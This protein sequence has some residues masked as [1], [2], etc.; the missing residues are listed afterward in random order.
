MAIDPTVLRSF[1]PGQLISWLAGRVTPLGQPA[2]EEQEMVAWFADLSNFSHLTHQITERERA[3]PELVGRLLDET[4]GTILETVTRYG[5]EVL[6]FAG[7]SVLSTWTIGADLDRARA[8][9]LASRCGLEVLGLKLPEVYSELPPLDLRVGIGVGTGVL[10]ELGG[11]EQQWHFAIG[12]APFDQ[13]GTASSVARPGEVVLSPEAAATIGSAARGRFDGEGFLRLT[14]VADTEPPGV[15]TRPEMTP[16]LVGQLRRFLAPPVLK[17]IE[18]G[19]SEWLAEF[20]QVT[21]LFVNLPRLDSSA[22]AAR[23][24]LQDV[25]TKTQETLVKYEGTLNRILDDDKGVT[26]FASFGLPPFAHEEDPYLAVQAAEEVQ[27][28][29]TQMRLEYGIGIATGRA[30]CGAYG[31]P[32]RREYTTIG[33]EVNLAARLMRAA[34]F[35]ILCDEATVRSAR[36]IEFHALDPRQLRGWD[37]PVPVFK[38]LWEK[39]GAR[40]DRHGPSLLVGRESEQ[41]QLTAWLGAL[42]RA[43]SSAVVVVEGE[44]G[45]GKTALAGDLIR[46]AG[47]F[48][49][50][51]LLGSALPVAQAPYQAWRDVIVELLGLTDIRS[52][53]RRQEMV[54][55]SLSRWPEFAQWEALLNS[56]L[57][58]Q[59]PETASTRGMSGRNRR[60]STVELLVALLSEAA[61]RS[62]L[63]IVLDDLQWFD[64]ASW[65]VT[66]AAARKVSPMLLVLLTR[67]IPQRPEQL[68]ELTD[69]GTSARMVLKPISEQDSLTLAEERFDAQEMGADVAKVIVE[70]AE[71]IPF[72]IEELALSLRESGAVSIDRGKVRLTRPA[73]ELGIPHTLSS[74]V[75]G[76]IDHLAPQLQLTVKVASVIG[77]SFDTRALE[78]VHPNHPGV[79]EL[80]GQ[81]SELIDLDLIVET[82]PE[83]YDFK[84]ALTRDTAYNLLLFD[85]RR[86]IHRSVATFFE[87]LPE[88]PHEPQYALLAYHWDRGD[89]PDKA[90]GY[91]EK[92]GASALRKGANREAIAAHTRSLELVGQYPEEFLDV[93]RL[94]QS[95]WHLEIGQAHEASGDFDEAEKNLYR[96]MGLVEVHVSEKPLRRLGRFIREMFKQISHVA[97][98]GMI[99][100]P[101]DDEEK[102]RLAQAA[103]TAALIGETY[104]FTGDIPGFLVLN[105]VAINLGEKSGEPLVAGLAY[106]S[107]GYLVGTLRLRR[108]ANRYFRQARAAE[109]LETRTE[110]P[111]TPHAPPLQEMGPGHLIAVALSESVLALT[112]NE[113]SQA[114]AIVTEALD[115]CDRLGDK[116]SAGIALAVRGFVSYSS[117]DLEEAMYDYDQLLA[118]AR[119]RSNREHEG[120]ATSFVIPVLLA[121][122]HLEEA[123]AMAASAMSILDDVDPLTVP[124]IHGTRSQVQLRAGHTGEARASAELALEA[125]DRTPFF[126]YLAG[127]AGLLDTLLE[128][129]AAEGDRASTNA[130]DLAKLTQEGLRKMR[131]FARVL[132]FARPK[133]WLFK[134]RSEL[135]KGRTR[136]GHRSLRKGL[137]LARSNGFTWDEGLLHLELAETLPAHDAS[138]GTHQIEARRLF[139]KVG[140]RHDL[141]RLAAFEL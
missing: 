10:M 115:R 26:L 139:D 123:Q 34:R 1:L 17:R 111:P 11:V 91:F 73:D 110:F 59:F 105:L 22:R 86:R 35:E 66:L 15:A 82:S 53:E 50:Q 2:S 37:R 9:S 64:S 29:L 55:E 47:S 45:I 97:L 127:Y 48:D 69:L 46:T 118:S 32:I 122:E 117:G 44:A 79:D 130:R 72:F 56:V 104:Y 71:G 38:P 76:R 120:W 89:D 125:I 65:A 78:A 106:S 43:H 61:T 96:A 58:L 138:R 131:G 119:Q 41:I 20:R 60:D 95:Q 4:F 116:Y 100:I 81:L 6:E 98:P 27:S 93:S 114:R 23:D 39:T 24:A 30:F 135:L 107:L 87:S 36:R 54:R 74:V 19:Q 67:P 112:F 124:I 102:A 3:G 49:V 128:L 62:P 33:R 136:R 83:S 141:D 126:I 137:I 63:L 129:W 16:D 99:R 133:Y 140:S 40:A 88:E 57:D 70:A 21:S 109:D 28:A 103:R 84:H 90:L 25:V 13:I 18:P 113:W 42:V 51:I 132:P 108:L 80:A 12:G 68:A 75:L 134:G 101:R 14:D 8:L 7:D 92:T 31:S 121:L 5:G 52:L 85:Q 94:R 77:R